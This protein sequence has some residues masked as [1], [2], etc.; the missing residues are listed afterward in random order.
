[1]LSV[2]PANA[3]TPHCT[4][5]HGPQTS[6]DGAQR[7]FRA[8]E[9]FMAEQRV[10]FLRSQPE[11]E[12]E[13]GPCHP[14]CDCQRARPTSS[15][16]GHYDSLQRLFPVSAMPPVCAVLIASACPALAEAASPHG[17]LPRVWSLTLTLAVKHG[18]EVCPCV[19]WAFRSAG[20]RTAR[21]CSGAAQLP[22]KQSRARLRQTG[23]LQ[24]N[25]PVWR[26][27]QRLCAVCAASEEDSALQNMHPVMV[28]AV[29]LVPTAPTSTNTRMEGDCRKA[30]PQCQA[31]VAS[32]AHQQAPFR[33][34]VG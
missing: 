16:E 29:S 28:A 31:C 18:T 34:L 30:Q 26:C 6:E 13:G 33:C 17:E 3:Q 19:A 11:V 25:V 4:A 20:K 1:M 8:A 21:Q 32:K 5:S 2:T 24:A 7:N 9:T 12:Q 10:R 27:Y 23:A 15:Q 22:P 14:C